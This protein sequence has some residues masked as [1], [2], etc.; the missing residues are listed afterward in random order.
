MKFDCGR[1]KTKPPSI[2]KEM[3]T[4]LGDVGIRHHFFGKFAIAPANRNF[5]L[6][7]VLA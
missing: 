1:R 5:V 4:A 6:F 2:M 7:L 3:Q